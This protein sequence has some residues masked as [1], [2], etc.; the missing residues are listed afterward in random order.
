MIKPLKLLHELLLIQERK[1]AGNLYHFT[2]LQSFIHIARWGELQ[3]FKPGVSS[4]DDF[5]NRIS[6]GEKVISV[7]RNKNFSF[8]TFKLE[9]NGDLISDKY[10]IV[11]YLEDKRGFEGVKA[12]GEAEEVIIADKL[13]LW[14]Y[15]IG[16]DIVKSKRNL[17]DFEE[18]EHDMDSNKPFSTAY[19]LKEGRQISGGN[20]VQDA[21]CLILNIAKLLP[22]VELGPNI[23]K[24]IGPYEHNLDNVQNIIKG[25]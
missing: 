6:K 5:R 10:K 18:L 23:K 19:K 22:H 25:I 8:N 4:Q 24:M 11:P 14:K 21:W 20:N 7:T 1:A 17:Q 15:L 16:I 13:N 9:L 12:F 2:T 3:G